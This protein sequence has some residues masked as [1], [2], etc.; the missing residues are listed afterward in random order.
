MFI[1]LFSDISLSETKDMPL[2][3]VWIRVTIF[4][5]GISNLFFSSYINV[6][7]LCFFCNLYSLV[8]SNSTGLIRGQSIIFPLWIILNSIPVKLIIWLLVIFDIS[9]V[10]PIVSNCIWSIFSVWNCFIFLENFSNQ[11]FKLIK[12]KLI[13]IS[14][15]F[16]FI[17]S[18]SSLNL[19]EIS[20]SLLIYKLLNFITVFSTV[21]SQT[22]A[23]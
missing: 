6:I 1:A 5:K 10:F 19:F 16:I 20:Y 2:S 12:V 3:K 11:L 4:S 13:A 18:I 8:Y 22:H 15:K 9:L 17:L 7:Y 14:L 23:M 21:G